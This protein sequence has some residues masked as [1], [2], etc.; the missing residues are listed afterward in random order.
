MIYCKV[1][2]GQILEGP[3]TLPPEIPV[4]LALENNWYHTIFLNMPH[5]IESECNKVTQIIRM[6]MSFVDD[7]VECVHVIEDKSPEDIEATTDLLMKIVRQERNKKLLESDWTQL[8]NAHNLTE[9]DKLLWE[10]YRKK[11]R[12]FTENVD[13]NNIVWP[14]PPTVL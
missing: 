5:H 7:H 3:R 4:E 9:N 14:T 11:L 13:L 1:I 6:Q 8:P 2:D 12:A 10:V